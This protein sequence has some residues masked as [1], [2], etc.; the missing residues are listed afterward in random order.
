MGNPAQINYGSFHDTKT[1][2]KQRRPQRKKIALKR[3]LEVTSELKT[4]IIVFAFLR[5]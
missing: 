2:S 1:N 4:A 5:H 3:Y